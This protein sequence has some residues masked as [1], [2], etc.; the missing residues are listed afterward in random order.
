MIETCAALVIWVDAET[1]NVVI[2]YDL[3]DGLLSVKPSLLG[4][5]L[6]LLEEAVCAHEQAQNHNGYDDEEQEELQ[7]LGVVCL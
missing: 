6:G 5:L 2:I 1:S 3:I 7:V 4:N